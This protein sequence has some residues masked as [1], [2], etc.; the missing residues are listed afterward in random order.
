MSRSPRGGFT[1]RVLH[2]GG[3][4]QAGGSSSAT[5][6]APLGA[7]PFTFPEYDPERQTK[8]VRLHHG[9]PEEEPDCVSCHA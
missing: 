7:D 3:L 8:D 2:T 1:S 4:T 6:P 5:P 9:V